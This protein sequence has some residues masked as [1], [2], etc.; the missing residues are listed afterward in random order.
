MDKGGNGVEEGEKKVR[1]LWRNEV[2]VAME[3]R[4]LAE[5]ALESKE[6]R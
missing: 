6:R 2:D 4:E 5:G 3:R 1:R